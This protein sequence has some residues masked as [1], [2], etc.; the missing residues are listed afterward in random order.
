MTS[1]QVTK[2]DFARVAEFILSYL[3][4]HSEDEHYGS[5]YAIAEDLIG[6]V[7]EVAFKELLEEEEE[8]KLMYSLMDKYGIA[9]N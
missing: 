1:T 6:Q 7:R 5:D 8:R 9:R 4:A 2:D 3:D